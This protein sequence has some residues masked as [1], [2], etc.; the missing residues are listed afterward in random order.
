MASTSSYCFSDSKRVPELL[1]KL[2]FELINNDAAIPLLA[3]KNTS[4][5]PS[6]FTS[7]TAIGEPSCVTPYGISFSLLNSGKLFS[8]FK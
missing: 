7:A 3:P 5:F 1:L 6:L 8:V 2:F 4:S